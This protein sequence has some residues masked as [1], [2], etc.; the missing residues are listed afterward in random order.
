MLVC[1]GFN[2][3]AQTKNVKKSATLTD[4]AAKKSIVYQ[5]TSLWED[6]FSVPANWEMSNT[7]SPAVDWEIITDPN[8]SP[9]AEF[10]PFAF[11]SMANGY[12]FIDSDAQGTTGIQSSRI[13]YTGNIDLSAYANVSLTFEQAHRRFQETTSVLVSVDNGV[14]WTTFTVN[15]GMVVNTNSANPGI[16]QVDISAAA[17]NQSQVKIGFQYDGAWDWFWAID[18]VK[19][20]ET[21]QNDLSLNSVYWGTMGAFGYRLPYTK[22][23]QSQ[24]QPIDFSG[25]IK[26]IGVT[27]QNDVQF[28]VNGGTYSGSSLPSTILSNALDTID[29]TTQ[30]T[31]AP[32]LGTTTFNFTASS[33]AIDENSL[34]NSLPS[35]DIEVTSSQ[36]ARDLGVQTS[37]SYNQGEGFQV[38]NK[39]DIFT[40]AQTNSISFMP[41]LTA[42]PGAS[43]YVRLYSVDFTTGDFIFEEESEPYTLTQSDL[44]NMV[45]LTLLSSRNLV[46]G[47]TY[48]AVVGAFGNGGL[49]NDLIVAVSGVS[50]AQTSNYYDETNTTWYY[51]T[52]TPIVRLNLGSA[53]TITSSDSDNILCEGGSLTLTSSSGTGNVWSDNSTSNTLLVSTPGTYTVNVGGITSSPIVVT[54]Q[55]IN[56][57]IS[58]SGG[59][60]SVPA[61]A[62][63]TFQWGTCTPV[64]PISGA[65][66]NP[67][68]A[69]ANGTY[70]VA[71]T[72]NG[73]TSVSTPCA[74]VNAL[75][76]NENEAFS[77]FS[78]FP[79]PASDNVAID[80]SLR[81]ESAVNVSI[82]DLSSKVVYAANLGNKT[83]GSNSLNVNTTAFANGIYVVNVITN[84]G[85]ATEKL[86]IGK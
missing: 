4:I 8:A 64:A 55:A 54:Q 67:Y 76:L 28:N 74:T 33:S 68:T 82:T 47:T 6:D 72:I 84:N 56:T 7:S 14:S 45:T 32:V 69:T 31:L 50:E 12:A 77:S 60:L 20:I 80:F 46:A 15:D 5:K 1:I 62:G 10:R 18:D 66:T 24:I 86:V 17:A 2:T 27:D 40:D 3:N 61:Q 36:Y 59:S 13:T 71:V 51:T 16:V 11:T 52:G 9:R 57:T 38:G 53:P 25:V 34:N 83:I 29:A 26:N 63:A 44:G 19:I 65:T 35:Q 49:D 78:V 81:A 39:F 41:A 21:Y 48:L 58:V 70:S 43:V 23:P 79:N 75:N 22:I 42:I 85:I 37:T 73:C 30:L